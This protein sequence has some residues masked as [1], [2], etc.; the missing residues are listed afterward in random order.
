MNFQDFKEQLI[1][2]VKIKWSQFQETGVYLN[3]KEKYDDLSPLGQKGIQVAGIIFVFLILVMTP[4]AW[5]SGS[6]SILE[7]FESRKQVVRQLLQ[8]KRDMGQAPQISTGYPTSALK[9]E[10]QAAVQQLGLTP[11]QIKGVEEVS[12][13]SDGD[14][15]LVPSEIQQA[16]VQLTVWKLNLDQFVK[17]SF[18]LQGLNPGAKLLSVDMKANSDDNH[19]YD[20]IYQVVMFSPPP[21]SAEGAQ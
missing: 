13:A 15:R 3:L 2:T 17:L 12:V 5:M 19:Y 21:V 14:S 11:D 1:E 16:G 8:L 20:I 18:R 6:S 9:S 4:W 10:I 7:S